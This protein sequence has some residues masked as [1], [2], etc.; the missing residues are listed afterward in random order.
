MRQ[1]LTIETNVILEN[2]LRTLKELG[3][4]Y[5]C[6]KD[7]SGKRLGPLV[8]YAGR[9]DDTHQYVGD[10]Y[11]NMAVI[12]EFPQILDHWAMLLRPRWT[13]PGTSPKVF[14]GAPLGG[15]AF[16]QALARHYNGRYIYMEKEVTE[17]KT[18]TTREQSRLVFNRHEV[19]AGDLVI[20]VEDVVNNFSTTKQM[21]AEVTRHGGTVVALTCLLNRSLHHSTH[22]LTDTL[23]IPIESVLRKPIPEY[24]QDDP[25]V[26]EDIAAGNIVW[27][28]KSEWPRLMAV[29]QQVPA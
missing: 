29:M 3:G 13:T 18:D 4:Y 20:L 15:L 14:C 17:V 25:A 16:A 23:S 26:I 9:Y 27:K 12:E 28:P 10:I 21:I 2:P 7:D 1:G 5:E 19:H 11:A 8:G 6:P 24:Q 22:F